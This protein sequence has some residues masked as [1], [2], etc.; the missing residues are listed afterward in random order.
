MLGFVGFR[1][2][3]V[4]GNKRANALAREAAAREAAPCSVPSKD[5]FPTIR[6]AVAE[7]WQERWD[8]LSANSKFG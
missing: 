4:A 2:T 7:S 8:G 1:A 6:A 5:A 3:L